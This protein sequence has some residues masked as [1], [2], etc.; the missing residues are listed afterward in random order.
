M[1]AILQ[2]VGSLVLLGT[3][4]AILLPRHPHLR[5]YGDLEYNWARGVWHRHPWFLVRLYLLDPLRAWTGI[6]ALRWALVDLAEAIPTPPAIV[7]GALL[8][9]CVGVQC[10]TFGK[11]RA[12]LAPVFYLSGLAIALVPPF[13]SLPALAS[14]AISVVA[15]R[16]WTAFFII[17]ALAMAAATI[18]LRAPVLDGLVCA[19]LLFIPAFIGWYAQT[20]LVTPSRR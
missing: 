8:V 16:T 18:L 14:A 9:P 5:S 19:G 1:N 7:V 12:K 13:V 6:V 3:P 4:G 15:L 11:S 10:L 17:G 20:T 2:A